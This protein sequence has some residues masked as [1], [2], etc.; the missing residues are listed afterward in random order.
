[1]TEIRGNRAGHLVLEL[2]KVLTLQNLVAPTHPTHLKVASYIF[3]IDLGANFVRGVATGGGVMPPPEIKICSKVNIGNPVKK[4]PPP[5]ENYN[6]PSL[7][8]NLI[9]KKHKAEM[10]V[11]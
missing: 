10:K 11:Y 7:I 5:P 8:I 1:M 6:Y 2:V 3:V 4:P 9:L